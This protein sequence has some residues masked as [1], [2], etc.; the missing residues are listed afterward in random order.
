MVQQYARMAYRL[1][2]NGYFNLRATRRSSYLG[3]IWKGSSYK[4]LLEVSFGC[5][6]TTARINLPLLQ[7]Q[8]QQMRKLPTYQIVLSSSGWYCHLTLT[9][10]QCLGQPEVV[11]LR[12]ASREVGRMLYSFFSTMVP[13][14]YDARKI[15]LLPKDRLQLKLLLRSQHQLHHSN[16]RTNCTDPVEIRDKR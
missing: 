12:T 10:D 9:L 2:M 15:L 1:L 13:S 7:K 4:I 16:Q 14:S 5:V 3:T 8:H 11:R 6:E